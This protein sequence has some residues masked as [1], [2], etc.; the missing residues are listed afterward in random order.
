[1]G[2]YVWW[3]SAYEEYSCPPCPPHKVPVLFIGLGRVRVGDDLCAAIERLANS[4]VQTSAARLRRRDRRKALGVVRCLRKSKAR[5]A[6]GALADT[7]CAG[8]VE[9][10]EDGGDVGTHEACALG[11]SKIIAEHD[12]HFLDGCA[13]LR[14][15]LID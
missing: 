1:M 4:N 7:E 8:A 5:R 3:G 10:T 11:R 9:N 2:S 6:P 15:V 12:L 13:E 14:K